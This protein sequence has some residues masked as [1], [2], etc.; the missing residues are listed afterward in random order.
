MSPEPSPQARRVVEA[1]AAWIPDNLEPDLG[2]TER[3][4]GRMAEIIER[5]TGVGEARSIIERMLPHLEQLA[6]PD[7]AADAIEREA[8]A[9]L[10]KHQPE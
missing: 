5:E 3:E 2:I 6:M 10:A 9:F 4:L 8:R 1:L 7:A